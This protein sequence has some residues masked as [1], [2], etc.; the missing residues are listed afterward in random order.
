MHVLEADNMPE[1]DFSSGPQA[2]APPADDFT[3]FSDPLDPV[4]PEPADLPT[5][6]LTGI[7]AAILALVSK[8]SSAAGTSNDM[9]NYHAN[10]RVAI[11]D[12]V[13]QNLV[14]VENGLYSVS[15]T[16]RAMMASHG[17]LSGPEEGAELTSAG[18]A[19]WRRYF[20]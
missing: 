18:Q 10:A 6:P 12:L 15:D 8:N 20:A 13:R 2:D 5:G 14:K 11:K 1:V 7:A 17:L 3:D 19:A 16:G 9:I 4:E